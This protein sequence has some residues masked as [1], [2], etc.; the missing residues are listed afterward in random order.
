M[1]VGP[2]RRICVAAALAA[3]ILA[4]ASPSPAMAAGGPDDDR[5][6][7]YRDNRSQTGPDGAT[8]RRTV[9]CVDEDGNVYYHRT[10][11]HADENG[12]TTRSATSG[13]ADESACDDDDNGG[14]FLGVGNGP[15]LVSMSVG[16]IS[17]FNNGCSGNEPGISMFNTC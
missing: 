14:G 15:G 13:D 11:K 1:R 8:S 6:S 12:T 4:L 10:T 2:P 9:S 17:M 7:T 5:G 16:D 3:P